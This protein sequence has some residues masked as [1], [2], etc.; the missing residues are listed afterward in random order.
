M[1]KGSRIEVQTIE[2]VSVAAGG[3]IYE[4]FTKPENVVYVT[5]PKTLDVTRCTIQLLCDVLGGGSVLTI[6]TRP[7]SYPVDGILLN[8]RIVSGELIPIPD[9]FTFE[10]YNAEAL[11]NGFYIAASDPVNQNNAFVTIV[12][13]GNIKE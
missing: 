10:N 11:Q 13:E 5:P 12:W 1:K 9:K 8:A 2:A 4:K 7:P 6:G 3:N